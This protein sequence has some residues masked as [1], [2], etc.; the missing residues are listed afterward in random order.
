MNTRERTKRIKKDA[1][2]LYRQ[3]VPNPASIFFSRKK[4]EGLK[5]QF[6]AG[7]AFRESRKIA[8]YNH[9][10]RDLALSISSDASAA[11]MLLLILLHEH[12]HIEGV[13]HEVGGLMAPTIGIDATSDASLHRTFL[14]LVYIFNSE[15]VAPQFD[16]APVHNFLTAR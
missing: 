14:M 15:R 7:R 8:I 4:I 11:L 16:L 6:I 13:E 12:A 1:L 10:P 9:F 5:G 2:L 3:I